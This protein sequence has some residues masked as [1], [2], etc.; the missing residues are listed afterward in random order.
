[1]TG[2]IVIT[3]FFGLFVSIGVQARLPW[4]RRTEQEGE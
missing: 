3:F 1:M 4:K 2:L